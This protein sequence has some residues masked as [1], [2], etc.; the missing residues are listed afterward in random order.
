MPAISTDP[1][2]GQAGYETADAAM[3]AIGT[4]PGRDG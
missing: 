4:D 3:A 2:R 1:G